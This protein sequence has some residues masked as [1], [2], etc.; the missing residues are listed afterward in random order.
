M[1]LGTKLSNSARAKI[2]FN[3]SVIFLAPISCFEA[4]SGLYGFYILF[5]FPY[6][7]GDNDVQS[8]Y[9]TMLYTLKKYI[10]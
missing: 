5:I 1:V 2:T 9:L 10:Y 8:Y 6:F 3:L 4:A 7:D